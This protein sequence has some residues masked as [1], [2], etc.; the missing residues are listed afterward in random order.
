MTARSPTAR[1]FCVLCADDDP[2]VLEVITALLRRE[3]WNVD[4][5]TDPADALRKV[6]ADAAAYD[7]IISDV[8]MP[9]LDGDRFL[10]GALRAGFRG[11]CI[12]FSASLEQSDRDAFAALGVT[13]IIA[14]PN[15]VALLAAV[16]SVG[17]P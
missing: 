11:R 10:A 8:R 14:K 4:A 9:P 2:K 5:T 12:V 7:V 1:G 15:L 13:E 17:L 6:E 3:G 16:R